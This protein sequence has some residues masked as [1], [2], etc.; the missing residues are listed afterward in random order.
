MDELKEL[1][2]TIRFEKFIVRD[3]ALQELEPEEIILEPV[4]VNNDE[5][6][7]SKDLTSS[8]AK[9]LADI[10]IFG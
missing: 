2:K 7:E 10:A 3:S 8:T 4:F 6:S 9:E 1:L 5:K